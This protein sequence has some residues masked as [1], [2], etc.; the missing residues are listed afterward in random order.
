MDVTEE[1]KEGQPRAF[2]ELREHNFEIDHDSVVHKD[3]PTKEE[4]H[5]QRAYYLANV[6]MIDTK[7]G[8]ILESLDKKGYLENSVV[9]FTSDHGDCLTDH[10]HSQKWTMYDI[11]TKMPLIVWSPGRFEANRRVDGLC[12]QMD[13]GPAILELAGLTPPKTME[14]KSLLPALQGTEWNPRD[15]VYAEHGKDHILDGTDFMSMVR[16]NEWKLV[17]FID[18]DEGQ[19]FDLVNDPDEVNNLWS[20]PDHAEKKQELIRELLEWRTRSTVH[21]APWASSFR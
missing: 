10:G 16:D 21:S 5:K 1:E 20:N 19:L 4:R 18:E 7:V 3:N 17:H 2:K 11:I 13:I 9:I 15:Y 8:E 6:T 14:A 12:Q